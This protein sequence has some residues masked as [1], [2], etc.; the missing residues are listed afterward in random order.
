MAKLY[1]KIAK[2]RTNVAY[3]MKKELQSIEKLEKH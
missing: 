1:D 2:N 3:D